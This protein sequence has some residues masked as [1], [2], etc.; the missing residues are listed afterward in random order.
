MAA[1]RCVALETCATTAAPPRAAARR[2][3]SSSKRVSAAGPRKLICA[4]VPMP[5]GVKLFGRKLTPALL[6]RTSRTGACVEDTSRANAATEAFDERSSGV[7][8][9]STRSSGHPSMLSRIPRA[10]RAPAWRSRTPSTT[11]APRAASARAVASPS[12][13]DAPVTRTVLPVR[14][15]VE[16]RASSSFRVTRDAGGIM[17]RAAAAR[18]PE[19][20]GAGCAAR[21]A[22][23]RLFLGGA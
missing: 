2:R 20:A 21:N 16:S 23:A 5:S 11:R 13:E 19:M 18:S 7:V 15:T 12:P 3:G 9:T 10:T 8:G 22:S 1:Y 14:S 6:T 17:A 4:I